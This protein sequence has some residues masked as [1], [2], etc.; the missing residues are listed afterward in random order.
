MWVAAGALAIISLLTLFA[1]RRRD[2]A[3]ALVSV[4]L[5]LVLLVGLVRGH[6][7]AYVLAIVLGVAGIA[8]SF[9]KS[10]TLGLAVLLCN[11]VVLVPVLMSTSYFF[12]PRKPTESSRE[13]RSSYYQQQGDVL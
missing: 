12:P 7:W 11:G 1:A 9:G 8:V 3:V 13:S 10:A 2:L 6:R 5:N 4:V